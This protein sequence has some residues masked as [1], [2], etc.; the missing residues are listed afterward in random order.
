MKT[1]QENHGRYR[2]RL[3]TAFLKGWD[4]ALISPSVASNPYRR[5]DFR[6]YWDNGRRR[7][8]NCESLPKHLL[9]PYRETA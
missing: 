8:L 5:C 9:H 3:E 4:S 1:W 2:L 6:Q 7:C